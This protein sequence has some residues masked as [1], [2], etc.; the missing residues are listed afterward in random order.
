MD[1]NTPSCPVAI[2]E[3]SKLLQQVYVLHVGNNHL[4]SYNLNGMKQSMIFCTTLFFFS[5]HT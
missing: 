1:L 4:A 2:K 5:R 3:P